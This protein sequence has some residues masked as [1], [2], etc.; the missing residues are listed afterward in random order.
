M[1]SRLFAAVKMWMGHRNCRQAGYPRVC[2]WP[3]CSGIVT[4]VRSWPVDHP[5]PGH[6]TTHHCFSHLHLDLASLWNQEPVS[7]LVLSYGT[8]TAGFFFFSR[9]RLTFQN[10][11]WGRKKEDNST[12]LEDNKKLSNYQSILFWGQ[13]RNYIIRLYKYMLR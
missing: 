12:H 1:V 6:C 3:L 5:G 10:S 13:R 9:C 11:F 8:P 4:S 2:Q 7:L